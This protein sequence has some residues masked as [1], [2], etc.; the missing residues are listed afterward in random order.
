MTASSSTSDPPPAGLARLA[1]RAGS[2]GRGAGLA[3]LAGALGLLL[4][5]GDG[6]LQ[7]LRLFGFDEVQRWQPRQPEGTPALIVEIDEAS[8]QRFG[9]WPWPRD[10]MADLIA[11]I[12][13]QHPKVLGIDILW[14]EPD[15]LSA[16]QWS[17]LQR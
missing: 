16:A 11:R 17:G 6:P 10:L 12:H 8:L 2:R 7:P 15:P 9:Q 1:R 14:P 4:G 3:A 5:A 13:A